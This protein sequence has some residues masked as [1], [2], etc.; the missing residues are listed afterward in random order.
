[1]ANV[2]VTGCSSGFGLLTA[3]KFA[4]AG[5]RV[6]ATVRDLTR[7]GDLEAARDAGDLPITILRLDV[8]DAAS[9][10]S[11]VGAALRTGPIDVLVNNAGYALAGPVEEVDEQELLAQFDT[12]VF[13]LVRVIQAVVPG[14]RARGT[15][16]IVNVSSAGV[17]VTFP[18]S[19]VYVGSKAAIGALSEAISQRG[20]VAPGGARD[21]RHVADAI[22]DAV[23][24]DSR[25]FRYPIPSN[26][27][28]RLD[29]CVARLAELHRSHDYVTVA[30][31]LASLFEAR[32]VPG[33]LEEHPSSA[34]PAV[35]GRGRR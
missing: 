30:D 12:N 16:T 1:M 15:G 32:E 2:L 5:H 18:F 6:F 9:V 21:P 34:S 17:Y 8:R 24:T 3:Q 25:Q 7:A 10:R 14:M 4:R 35:L 33:P 22:Y 27:G 29:E 19:G 28:G 20:G 31:A 23:V 26:A 11:A 13:G